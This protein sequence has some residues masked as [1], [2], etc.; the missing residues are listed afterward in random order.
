MLSSAGGGKAKTSAKDTANEPTGNATD[1]NPL[2]INGYAFDAE[3]FTQK[4]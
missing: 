3:M 2:N 4:L 1:N